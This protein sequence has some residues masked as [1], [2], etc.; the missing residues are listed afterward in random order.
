MLKVLA[1]SIFAF[2]TVMLLLSVIHMG[3]SS[4]HLEQNPV[5][6]YYEE[7]APAYSLEQSEKN[8]TEQSQKTAT[9]AKPKETSIFTVIELEDLEHPTLA[10]SIQLPHRVGPNNTVILAGK[11]AYLTTERHLHVIDVSI[12]KCPS[13]L[14]SL[15][16]GDVIG[17]ALIAGHYVVVSGK[18]QL[19]LVNIEH[20][21][22]PVLESTL[23]LPYQNAIK[24]FDVSGSHLYVMGANDTVYVFSIDFGQARHVKIIELENFG[25]ARLIKTIELEKRWWLLS[26]KPGSPEVEQI[27]LPTSNTFPEELWDPLLVERW[28][29]RLSERQFLQLR[30]SKQEKVRASSVFLVVEWLRDPTY[31]LFSFDTYRSFDDPFGDD[32]LTTSPII[33]YH[34]LALDFRKYLTAT[35]QKPLTRGI[36]ARA[37]AVANGKMQ[38][39]RPEPSSKTM[40]VE[41]KR[42]KQLMGPVTDFQISGNRLYIVTANGFFSVIP[43]ISDYYLRLYY[44]EESMKNKRSQLSNGEIRLFLPFLAGRPISLVVGEGEHYA[45][46]LSDPENSK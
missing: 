32:P 35:G 31:D 4:R 17:K 5:E 3:C 18:K 7:S 16:F 33:V 19:Y 27:P 23:H 22:H 34:N 2:L 6:R 9:S 36:P 25:Q 30:S 39:I 21:L 1:K 10:A 24:D 41:D 37:Y 38:E 45:Y 42:L 26:L 46:V 15:P 12:P 28:E 13:Y 40:D 44:R 8:A 20:P 14:T 43:I 29:P 11:H